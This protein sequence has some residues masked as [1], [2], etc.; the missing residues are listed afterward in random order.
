[1]VEVPKEETLVAIAA[2][3]GEPESASRRVGFDLADEHPRDDLNIHSNENI[4]HILAKPRIMAAW[5]A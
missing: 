4:D 1:M 5:Y 2:A 3:R